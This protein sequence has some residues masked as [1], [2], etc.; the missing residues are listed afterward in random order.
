MQDYHFEKIT[1]SRGLSHN[2]VYSI[3][4]D[5]RGFVWIG[6]REGLNVFDSYQVESYYESD[7]ITS[8]PSD[9]IRALLAHEKKVYIGTNKGLSVYDIEYDRF[10]PVYFEGEP[11]PAVSYFFQDSEGAVFFGTTRGLFRL[12]GDEEVQQIGK[13]WSISSICEYKQDVLVIAG[14]MQ[15]LII[16]S[17]GDAIR[18]YPY[19]DIQCVGNTKSFNRVYCVYKQSEEFLW[20]G[21]DNGLVKFDVVKGQFYS[22]GIKAINESIEARVIRTINEDEHG[23]LWLGTEQGLF[24]YNLQDESIQHYTQDLGGHTAALSDKS[25]YSI[26]HDSEGIMWLGTYFGGINYA[27]PKDR[28]FYK[29]LPGNTGNALSGKAVS[30]IIQTG[31]GN[32][33]IGTEDGGISIFDKKSG[34]YGYLNVNTPTPDRLNSNNIH[35]LHQ[36][37]QGYVWI[38]T[39]L[40][41]LHRYDPG[42]GQ[43]A[44]YKRI[45]GDSLSLQNNYVYS[46]YSDRNDQLWIGTQGGLHL[47]DYEKDEVVPVY[48]DVFGNRF[49]YDMIQDSTQNLWICTR[50]AGIF[51]ISPSG[52][53]KQYT[54]V[55]D[56]GVQSD[57]FISVYQDK[58]QR[59]WFGSLNGGLH[60]YL[61]QRD[62]FVVY[63]MSDGLPNNNI[64]GILEEDPNT[65][66][67]TSNKGLSRIRLDSFRVETFGIAHGLPTNQFNFK[68]FFKDRD[69]WMYFG[70]VNGL[71][72]FDPDSLNFQKEP[73]NIH[74]TDFK[75]FNEGR[76]NTDG[77]RIL[78]K[79]IDET[80]H[81]TRAQLRFVPI[82]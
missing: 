43:M 60:C 67:I 4:Q 64:Y 30:Q 9:E 41:G 70:T 80:D 58:R 16:N 11:L 31:D 48:P 13:D 42:T 47:Y 62:S 39:F 17:Q 21:T 75:L 71:C 34:S 14:L 72:Y 10:F 25:V 29:L 5:Y 8:L 54:T 20:L 7:T 51:R 49:I 36:D 15:L 27:K 53:I 12:A 59:L 74:F 3:T 24:I 1:T 76:R 6:T 81:I 44:N 56:R 52:K 18:S 28:S 79:H 69:G 61:P 32:I 2:T 45:P 57:E 82:G 73:P 40:G 33:W 66:W 78:E 38:G 77:S 37:H 26:Y 46:I 55:S 68:S 65:L 63:S 22:I 50:N 23:K 19:K 35:A